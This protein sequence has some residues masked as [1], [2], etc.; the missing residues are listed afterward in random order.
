M[1]SLPKT[2]NIK[3]WEKYL[4]RSLT[5]QEKKLLYNAGQEIQLNKHI[6]NLIENNKN[7]K[8]YIPDL[9]YSN[10]NCLYESLCYHIGD[11]TPHEIRKLTSTFLRIY[12]NYPNIFINQDITLKEMFDIQNEISYLYDKINNTLD[13]SKS[14]PAKYLS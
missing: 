3:I 12:R 6:Y 1:S 13:K 5:F 2:T 11:I 14:I 9:T 10:G 4:D 7:K 8:L